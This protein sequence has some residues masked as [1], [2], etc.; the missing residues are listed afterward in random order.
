MTAVV[1]SANKKPSTSSSTS[2]NTTPKNSPRS[3]LPRL[4][5][6]Y[7]HH[8]PSLGEGEKRSKKRKTCLPEEESL[9]SDTLLHIYKPYRHFSSCRMSCWAL[10]WN[11]FPEEKERKTPTVRRSKI[12]R[13]YFQP[14][15]FCYQ[16]TN[17]DLYPKD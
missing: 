13:N 4:L 9:S 15:S 3:P 7:C 6:D 2:T 17:K 12:S 1:A 14:F 8:S 11:Y 16:N 10:P 5:A